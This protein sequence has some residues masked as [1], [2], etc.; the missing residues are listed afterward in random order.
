MP[1][2]IT[3]ASDELP[4]PRRRTPNKLPR[5]TA[6]LAVAPGAVIRG[7]DGWGGPRRARPG[8]GAV[9]PPL[10]GLARRR[11]QRRCPRPR[12]RQAR[13]GRLPPRLRAPGGGGLPG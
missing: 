10:L 11:P 3:T 12:L 9:L 4:D 5:L 2:P 7:A 8:Q 13:P 1:P 6:P